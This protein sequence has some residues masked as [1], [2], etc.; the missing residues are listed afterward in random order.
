[1]KETKI[2]KHLYVWVFNFLFGHF[3]IDRFVRGQIGMGIFKL[4]FNWITFGIWGLINWIISL[5]KAYGTYS[6]TQD[7]TFIAGKYSK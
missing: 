1:M 4:L 7:I 3:G 5:V 6:D 2:N